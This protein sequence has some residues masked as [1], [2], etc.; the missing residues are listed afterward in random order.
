MSK[1][2]RIDLTQFQGITEGPW[3][4]RRNDDDYPTSHHIIDSA[5]TMDWRPEVNGES[6]AKAIAAVPA[7][8]DEL[9]KCYEMID[10]LTSIEC[11]TC[12]KSYNESDY[13]IKYHRITVPDDSLM[14][15]YREDMQEHCIE[16]IAPDEA[17]GKNCIC[18]L[19]KQWHAGQNASE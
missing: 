7:L 17:I 16:C 18:D 8:I 1:D 12:N 6:D 4:C 9:K 5:G 19:C 15:E 10:S 14:Y 2:E 3:E 11:T 13:G